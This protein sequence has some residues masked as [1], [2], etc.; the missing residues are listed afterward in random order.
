MS[1]TGSPRLL[2]RDVMGVHKLTAGGGY[3]YLTRQVAVHDATDRD[4]EGLTD[5]Y[6]EKGESPRSLVRCRSRRLRARRGLRGHRGPYAEQPTATADVSSAEKADHQK[7]I[8]TRSVTSAGSNNGGTEMWCGW[9][10]T[11]WTGAG[12]GPQH[13]PDGSP[14]ELLRLSDA[15]GL[16]KC[17]G[18]GLLDLVLGQQRKLQVPREPACQCALSGRRSARSARPTPR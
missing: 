6:A 9:P 11:R 4:H 13:G 18:H 5:Y 15:G 2:I 1:E 7:R 10:A 17:I 12:A 16:A 3:T 14:A 8:V